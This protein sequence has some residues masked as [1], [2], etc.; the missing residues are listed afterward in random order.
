MQAGYL[1]GQLLDAHPAMSLVVVNETESFIY[2]PNLPRRAI[3]YAVVFLNQML[4]TRSKGSGGSFMWLLAYL[5]RPAASFQE[6]LRRAR[7]SQ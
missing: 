6:S 2:K 1:L 4:L 7:A 5:E 3:Y